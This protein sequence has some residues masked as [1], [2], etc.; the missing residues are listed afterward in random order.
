M[1]GKESVLALRTPAF[2][3]PL[4]AQCLGSALHGHAAHEVHWQASAGVACPS[5]GIVLIDATLWIQSHASV[6]CAICA[7]NQI[8]EPGPFPIAHGPP[9][10]V[11]TS[12]VF[13]HKQQGRRGANVR[14]TPLLSFLLPWLRFVCEQ[15]RRLGRLVQDCNTPQV[16]T[17]W[18]DSLGDCPGAHH[19]TWALVPVDVL[20]L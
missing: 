14:L 17:C 10:I 2:D 16:W 8:D 4:E 3:A 11:H 1:L 19:L 12:Q 5:T 20:A 13:N 18:T 9:I 6:Q 7:L 15:L